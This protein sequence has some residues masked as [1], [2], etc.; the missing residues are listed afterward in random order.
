MKWERGVKVQSRCG[1]KTGPRQDVGTVDIPIAESLAELIQDVGSED[2]VLKLGNAQRST[3]IKN[4]ARRVANTTVS[5]RRLREEAASAV[6]NNRETLKLL[7]NI[8]DDAER[9]ATREKLV[10][11]KVEELREKYEAQRGLI[12]TGAAPGADEDE[13]EAE[14]PQA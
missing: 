2:E 9:E 12:P 8:D 10:T 11:E 3:N 4:E 1:R 13:E 7:A 6:T 5:D 14:A